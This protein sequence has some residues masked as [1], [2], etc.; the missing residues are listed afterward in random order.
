MAAVLAALGGCHPHEGDEAAWAGYAEAEY[1]RVAAPLGGRLLSLN[2]QRGA[3]VAAGAPLFTLE[4]DSEA[5]ALREAQAREQRAQAVARDLQKG[6]RRD[7]LAAAQAA[8]DA[9]EASLKDSEQELQRQQA[10]AHQGFTSGSN[11]DALRARRD[12]DAARVRQLQAQLRVAKEGARSD[13][14]QAAQADTQ[15]AQAVVAQSA[16]RVEQKA[17][18]APVAARVEDTLYRPGEWVG[19]G[20]PV[21]TLLEPGAI[22]LRFFVPEGRL[23]EVPVGRSVRVRCDGCGAPINATVRYVASQ[24]EFTPPVIYSKDNRSKLVYLVEAW[25]APADAAKLHPGQPVDVRLADAH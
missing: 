9:A 3:Q 18:N 21:V 17:V 11:L 23:G 1:T 24:A 19:A 12:A 4:R 14:Q 25:P 22:K 6:Q 10:L 16:W 13:A 7:E 15:A 8:V 5:A 2:V 20:M